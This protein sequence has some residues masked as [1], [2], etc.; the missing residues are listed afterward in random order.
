MIKNENENKEEVLQTKLGCDIE[1]VEVPLPQEKNS[2]EEKTQM[3]NE[4]GNEYFGKPEVYDY[5]DVELGPDFEYD[6]ALLKDFNDIAAKYNLSQKSANELMKMA[7]RL[8]KQTKDNL[9][10]AYAAT[11]HSKIQ[12]YKDALINDN[13]IGGKNLADSLK[14]ANTAYEKFADDEVQTIFANS[15]LNHHPKI[16]KMFMQ[17]GK[18]MQNDTIHPAGNAQP[19][20]EAREDILFPSM[21]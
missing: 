17:I 14:V 21:Q 16:V 15:G 3:I 19:Y 13:E 8:S 11:T 20:R 1:N 12:S 5:K 7:V 4:N 10:A 6:E 9:D 2:V 18:Q